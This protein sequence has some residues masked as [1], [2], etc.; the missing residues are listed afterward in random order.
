MDGY[1]VP[2]V[3]I[4]F[5]R[6]VDKAQIENFTCSASDQGWKGAPQDVIRESPSALPEASIQILVA[7]VEDTHVVGV[8]VFEYMDDYCWVNTL[9]TRI[10]H[11]HRGIGTSL[12]LAVMAETERVHPGISVRSKVHKRNKFMIRI[13]TRLMATSARSPSEPNYLNTLVKLG[14]LIE[15]GDVTPS[16]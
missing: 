3:P 7:I 8:A 10:D 1:G 12:K 16:K 4:R 9:G 11:Q 14:S 2:P 6:D 13:N 15:E 5:Y